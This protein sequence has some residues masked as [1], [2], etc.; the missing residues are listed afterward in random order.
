MQPYSPE[1]FGFAAEVHLGV[2]VVRYCFI[3]EGYARY[4]HVLFDGHEL[5]H[6][7][8]IVCGR[9]AESADLRILLVTEEQQLRPRGRCETDHW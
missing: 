5:L 9:H 2:K 4:G 6:E 3:V 1:L 8:R 7:E